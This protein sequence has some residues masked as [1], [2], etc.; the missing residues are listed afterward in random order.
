V[1]RRV[2]VEIKEARDGTFKYVIVRG[3]GTERVKDV[4]SVGVVTE[5]DESLRDW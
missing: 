3:F 2:N 4:N 1:L 5:D